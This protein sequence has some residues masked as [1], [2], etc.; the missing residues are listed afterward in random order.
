MEE[1]EKIEE[2]S[3]DNKK[4]LNDLKNKKLTGKLDL[5]DD[6]IKKL[7]DLKKKHLESNAIEYELVDPNGNLHV[8]KNISELCRINN[9]DHRCISLVLRGLRKHHKYWTKPGLEVDINFSKKHKQFKLKDQHGNIYEGTNLT[10]F[11][12]D[13]NL[14]YNC[15]IRVLNGKRNFHLGWIKVD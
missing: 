6:D 15:I 13:H 12:K 10:Q 2:P 3:E 8:G 1:L 14:N 7:E 11:C 5:N 9:L 4:R